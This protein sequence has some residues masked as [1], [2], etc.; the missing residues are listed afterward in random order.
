MSLP[1]T[2]IAESV[3]NLLS[4]VR[5]G[6]TAAEVLATIGDDL[7]PTSAAVL[8]YLLDRCAAAEQ[9]AVMVGISATHDG[10]PQAKALHELWQRWRTGYGHHVDPPADVVINQLARVRDQTITRTLGRLHE[11]GPTGV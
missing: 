2:R 10:T 5:G 3:D 8:A 7:E 9:V 1:A 11:H 6:I 4:Y